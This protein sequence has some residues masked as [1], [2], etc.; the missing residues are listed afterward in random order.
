MKIFFILFLLVLPFERVPKKPGQWHELFNGKNLPGW[1]TYLGPKFDSLG[2]QLQEKPIGLN[3]DPDHVFS[4]VKR[5]GESMI[6]I[7]GEHFGA[8][9]TLAAYENYHFQMMFKWGELTWIH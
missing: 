5:R 4:V 3:R 6:R 9:A 1:D 8:I 2:H 7:S